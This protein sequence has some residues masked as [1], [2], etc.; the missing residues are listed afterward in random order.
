MLVAEGR[1]ARDRGGDVVRRDDD[2]EVD[3]RL[4]REARHRRAADVLDGDGDV[5]QRGCDR[6]PQDLEEARPRRVVV[7][8][9][10]RHRLGVAPPAW[11]QRVFAPG[12]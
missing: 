3:D 7:E 11:F 1:E 6:A 2:I 10:D 4:G 5:R 8:D 12:R 9:D